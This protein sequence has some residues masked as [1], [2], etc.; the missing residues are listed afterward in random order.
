MAHKR[1]EKTRQLQTQHSLDIINTKAKK[2]ITIEKYNIRDTLLKETVFW[3]SGNRLNMSICLPL[4]ECVCRKI[5]Y[6]GEIYKSCSKCRSVYYCSKECQLA[7]WSQHKYKCDRS[8][9]SRAIILNNLIGALSKKGKFNISNILT[10]VASKVGLSSK[11]CCIT[12]TE[13]D[14]IKMTENINY[15]PNLYS[16]ISQEEW[17]DVIM[18]PPRLY[19]NFKIR[20]K[21]IGKNDDPKAFDSL[22][23]DNCISR[24]VIILFSSDK[25]SLNDLQ[26]KLLDNTKYG[27][28]DI[29]IISICAMLVLRFLVFL[30]ISIWYK[31]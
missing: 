8:K 24:S 15:R 20:I 13:E 3:S 6:I 17:K 27:V 21:L 25:K 30:V 23:D 5:R 31:L 1:K 4:Y 12:L 19:T 22:N 14:A 2:L 7:H 10:S 29:F 18:D 16:N 28:L 11:G 26:K 9:C